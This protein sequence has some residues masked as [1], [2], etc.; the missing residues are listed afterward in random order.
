MKLQSVRDIQAAMATGETSSQ[1]LV[2]A[3]LDRIAQIDTG[4]TGLRAIL[5]VNPDAL[6]I[7][8][9]CDRERQAGRLVVH[10]TGFQSSSRA[11]STLRTP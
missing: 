11:T 7:A 9:R 8:Q 10:F 1:A 3:C 2:A 6:S 5:E 4:E